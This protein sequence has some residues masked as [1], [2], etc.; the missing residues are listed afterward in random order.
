MS[1]T[2]KG[3]QLEPGLGKEFYTQAR[4]STLLPFPSCTPELK[5]LLLFSLMGSHRKTIQKFPHSKEGVG[6]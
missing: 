5:F 3:E 6:G 4:I 1:W 2:W